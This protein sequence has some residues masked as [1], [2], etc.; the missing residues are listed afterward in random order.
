ME[1]TV[2]QAC[3][4]YGMIVVVPPK[5]RD[6]LV[7]QQHQGSPG[8]VRSKELARSYGWWPA[9]ASDLEQHDKRVSS[10]AMNEHR[11]MV[12]ADFALVESTWTSLDP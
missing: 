1:L 9:I 5:H 4:M 2:H 8:I 7:E 12:M 3:F 10:N 6:F 11:F